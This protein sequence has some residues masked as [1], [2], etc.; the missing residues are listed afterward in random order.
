MPY[1]DE[2][3]KNCQSQGFAIL[4]INGVP[5]QN[6]LAPGVLKNYDLIGLQAPSN[7]WADRYDRVHAYPTNYLLD[8]QGRIMAHPRVSDTHS[9][10][11]FRDPARG[12]HG[13]QRK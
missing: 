6:R 5:Q 10:K 3:A 13:A 2:V 8:A 1:L 7:K 4:A 12:P 11:G 9:P